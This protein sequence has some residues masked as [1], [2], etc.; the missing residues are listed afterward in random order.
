[1]PF[2]GYQYTV[3]NADNNGLFSP[4]TSAKS[5]SFDRIRANYLSNPAF[6]SYYHETARVPYL[7]DVYKRQV[8]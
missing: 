2:Y 8:S 6:Q 4:F 3:T 5:V 7:L 1:M